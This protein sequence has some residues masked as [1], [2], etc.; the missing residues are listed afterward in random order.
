MTRFSDGPAKDQVLMLRRAARFIR[1][2]EENGKWDALDQLE[3]KPRPTEKLY[4]YE[5][6]R[7]KV[8]YA[9]IDCR[10][11]N[12]SA[13]GRYAIAEYRIV[14]PQPTDE[15]MRS[16]DAWAAWCCSKA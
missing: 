16:N 11:K 12:K 5:A 15:Q 4:A 2:T 6:I 13:S 1:V 10:G 3:D 9:L 7:E 8:G 14:N